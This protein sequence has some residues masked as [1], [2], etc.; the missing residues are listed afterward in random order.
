M[1]RVHVTDEVS[2]LRRVLP[3]ILLCAALVASSSCGDRGGA[4]A[5][6]ANAGAS[7]EASKRDDVLIGY[8]L[9]ADTLEDESK[10]RW[11][12]LVKKLTLAGPI[13]EVADFLEKIAKSAKA[14]AKELKAL[15]EESPDVTAKPS[16]PSAIGDAITEDAKKRGAKELLNRD[17]SFNTRFLLLQA[18]AMRMI[19]VIA[20]ETGEIDTNM[21]R[22][23]WLKGVS[24][25]YEGY[26]D[27]L[28]MT[29]ERHC[30]PDVINPS[31]EKD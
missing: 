7:R 14:D 24:K 6:Q 5:P 20:A 23:M 8:G 17:S 1:T 28:V 31:P 27:E 3:P 19:A 13:D 22:K 9:L 26:R 21:H 15:R 29:F 11:L 10:L 16:H 25:K 18:Q 2:Y 4:P 30:G 12:E